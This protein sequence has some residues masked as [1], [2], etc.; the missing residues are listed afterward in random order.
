[1]TDYA[2]ARTAMVDRQ[3]RPSDVTSFPI[4][5]AMLHI[6]RHRFVS[7]A[8]I[9]IA[10]SDASLPLLPGREILAPRTFAKMLDGARIGADD[11]VLDL[12]SG[13]GYST[14]V[15]ARMAAAVIAL[16][17]DAALAETAAATLLDLEI[18]NAIL[19]A[20][21]PV[22]G[23]SAHG[24]FDAIFINGGVEVVPDALLL[25][26]KEG[27]RLVAV[28]MTAAMGRAV[29]FIRSGD[30]FQP[31]PLFDAAAPVLPGFAAKEAFA[32]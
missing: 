28:Q 23:D 14:A 12:A 11:L 26:L 9:D 1:M 3:V 31:R 27:G 21:D 6:P 32:F 4:I 29:A 30:R 5:D 24:P 8:H 2:A 13:L 7:P 22:A 20:G 16:E 19:Q 10:Y 25:Q 17:P 18:D 15:I